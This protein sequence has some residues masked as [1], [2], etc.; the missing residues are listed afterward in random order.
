MLGRLF[1]SY[2]PPE[3]PRLQ[4]TLL[5]AHLPHTALPDTTLFEDAYTRTILYGTK[6]PL[7]LLGRLMNAA[8][9]RLVISQDTHALCDRVVLHDST[10]SSA[11]LSK[12][13]RHLR[14]LHNLGA[15]DTAAVHE[16]HDHMFG[17]GLASHE[18]ERTTK[19]H[20][21]PGDSGPSAGPLVLVTRIFS[22]YND[23]EP[24]AVLDTVCAANLRVAIGVCIPLAR[25]ADVSLV[26]STNWEEIIVFFNLLE[27]VVNT[28]LMRL[29]RPAAAGMPSPAGSP[30]SPY[31]LRASPMRAASHHRFPL[32]VLQQDPEITLLFVRVVQAIQTLALA[33]RLLTGY[34]LL[35]APATSAAG[36]LK[37]TWTTELV[38]WLEF[39]DGRGL[40]ARAQ[41]PDSGPLF[42]AALFATCLPVRHRLVHKPL[43]VFEHFPTAWTPGDHEYT[44]DTPKEVVRVVITST[45]P[46]VAKKAIFI[47][48]RLLPEYAPVLEPMRQA[49]LAAWPPPPV[50][51][52]SLHTKTAPVHHETTEE[53]EHHPE[54]PAEPIRPPSLPPS[55]TA[56]PLPPRLAETISRASTRVQPSSWV[57]LRLVAVPIQL[58]VSS[59]PAPVPVIQPRLNTLDATALPVHGALPPQ[60]LVQLLLLLLLLLF[61]LLYGGLFMDKWRLQFLLSKTEPSMAPSENTLVDS[62][63]G[64]PQDIRH[65][66][67]PLPSNDSE[68]WLLPRFPSAEPPAA[69]RLHVP[70]LPPVHRTQTT[71]ELVGEVLPLLASVMRKR[72]RFIMDGTPSVEHHGERKLLEV[73]D[74]VNNGVSYRAWRAEHPLPGEKPLL[75]VAGYL[76]EFCPDFSIQACRPSGE[77]EQQIAEAMAADLEMYLLF[78]YR[79]VTSRTIIVL[80]KAREIKEAFVLSLLLQGWGNH[81]VTLPGF[82]PARGHGEARVELRR[83]FKPGRARRY[84]EAAQAIDQMFARI[85]EVY[86]TPGLSDS[87]IAAAV[88]AI[89]DS[90]M[91]TA[92]T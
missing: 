44:I 54:L 81:P 78:G 86:S 41:Y 24:L 47:L 8:L 65:G 92:A 17:S 85:D 28:R 58:S 88:D 6:Q 9:F 87:A 20:L 76:P 75:P 74:V 91:Q 82:H 52:V 80:L 55:R 50:S 89:M 22:V 90:M 77:V 1:R 3:R 61:R 67:T 12:P 11:P 45:N 30:V 16:L 38:N 69:I 68:A 14:S 59:G 32:H 84:G 57:Q 53:H 15:S 21:L 43:G 25:A 10:A 2:D 18:H 73:A 34:M 31:P 23:G 19:L 51:S 33:P 62:K 66:V 37:H 7:R 46:L 26:V 60:S 48:L 40:A 5:L 42:M 79:H 29:L 70:V 83:V 64:T 71:L 63:W 72:C 56:T 27:E 39:K 49:M 36:E 35:P 13:L 4:H